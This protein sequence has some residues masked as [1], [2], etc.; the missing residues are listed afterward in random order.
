MAKRSNMTVNPDTLVVTNTDKKYDWMF[1]QT[2]TPDGKHGFCWGGP[3]LDVNIVPY[4]KDAATIQPTLDFAFWLV[5]LEHQQFLSQYLNPIR[6]SAIK[7]LK[8]PMLK[9]HYDNYIPYGRQRAEADGG[10]AREV[11]EALEV[12]LQTLY[13]PTDPKVAVGQFCT[14]VEGL[15]WVV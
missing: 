10:R 9:W 1:V 14:T 5:N 7:D 3:K 11:C 2:P 12:L 6:L 4:K 15:Q 8:D 13:L